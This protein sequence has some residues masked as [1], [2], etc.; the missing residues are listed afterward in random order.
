MSPGHFSVMTA[1]R[2]LRRQRIGAIAAALAEPP[3][4]DRERVNARGRELRR[5]RLPRL[6]RGVAHVQQEHRG[7]GC[8][9]A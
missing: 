4:V 7:P 8:A 1:L 3:I 6:P 5:Q 2:V 9:A